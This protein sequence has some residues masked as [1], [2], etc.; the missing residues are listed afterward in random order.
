MSHPADEGNGRGGRVPRRSDAR[1]AEEIAK[2]VEATIAGDGLKLKMISNRGV[3][4]YPNGFPETFCTDHWR[5]RF[6]A[7]NG[8]AV[9]Y[10]QIAALMGRFAD[11]GLD[12]IKTENLCTFDGEIGYSTVQGE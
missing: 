7:V 8:G 4:V 5:C 10:Q 1:S 6:V 2:V 11:S 9:S 12:F 3:K